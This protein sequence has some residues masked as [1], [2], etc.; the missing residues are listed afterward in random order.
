MDTVET[1]AFEGWKV[2]E[3]VESSQIDLVGTVIP[4][5]AGLPIVPGKP[6][7]SKKVD[8]SVEGTQAICTIEIVFINLNPQ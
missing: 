6:L 8:C 4:P 7:N 5:R 1:V 3:R 2:V